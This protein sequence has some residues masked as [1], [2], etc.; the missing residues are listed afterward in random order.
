MRGGNR[1]G[2]GAEDGLDRL[3][4]LEDGHDDRELGAA[5][6][7]STR[8]AAREA[9]IRVGRVRFGADPRDDLVEH[10]VER[11]RRLEAEDVARLADV[12]D[13]QLDVVLEG[14]V[15]DVAEGRAVAWILR[16]IVSASSRTVVDA[17]VDRLKSSLTAAG[18]SI[19][20]RMPWARSPP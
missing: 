4:F 2:Q 11:R 13:A 16:Q 9:S 1:G 14:R 3:A 10:R 19:A 15:A 6:V 20:S 7:G 12:R 8:S 18:D 5:V 17:A